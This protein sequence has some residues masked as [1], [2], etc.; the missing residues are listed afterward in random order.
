MTWSPDEEVDVVVGDGDGDGG[1]ELQVVHVL[2]H[3]RS[4]T[5]QQ[6]AHVGVDSRNRNIIND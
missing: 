5:T 1:H 2:L 6:H 4:G 3:R